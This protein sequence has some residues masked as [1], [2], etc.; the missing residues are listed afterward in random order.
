[1][2]CWLELCWWL[3]DQVCSLQ[4]QV[5]S[6]RQELDKLELI[7]SD[8]QMEKDSLEGAVVKL[9]QELKTREQKLN[10]APV[11]KV[12]HNIFTGF[13]L[14]LFT[15]KNAFSNLTLYL[16]THSILTAIFQVNL[17]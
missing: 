13:I 10:A 8:W 7:R 1:M 2:E 3:C 5:E 14:F 4:S 9:R 16:D 6:Y 17:G 11:G 12:H 15:L